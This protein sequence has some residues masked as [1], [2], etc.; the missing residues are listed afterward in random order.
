MLYE[1]EYI[2]SF[3]RLADCPKTQMPEFAFAG[4]SNVGKSSLI[5]AFTDRKGL[6]HISKTPGKT[7]MIN[8]FNIDDLWYLVDLPGYG[9]AQVSKKLRSKWSGM[10]KTYLKNREQ[11][12]CTFL[13]LDIR[14]KPQKNDL[15]FMNW[16]GANRVPFVLV[17]TKTDKVKQAEV[18]GRVNDYKRELLKNWNELPD[19]FLTSAIK[20]RGLTKLRDF[21]SELSTS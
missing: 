21:I 8:F 15:E 20:R 4:R 13:L 7:S 5:N 3:D 17:F 6:A 18:V 10:L 12:F 1:A 16:M 19:I 2:G 14:I 9:Y 11:L